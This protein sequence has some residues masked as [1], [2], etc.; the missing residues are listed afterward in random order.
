MHQQVRIAPDRRGEMHIR[1]EGEAEVADVLRRVNRALQ[2][3]QQDGLQQVEV[4]TG[5]DLLQDLGVVLGSR[6]RA[7]GELQP[8]LGE[9]V[10]QR[11]DPVLGGHLVH[12]VQHRLA[13]LGDEIAGADV[14]R[15]HALLDQAVRVVTLLGDDF[16]DLAARVE[17]HAR[18]DRFEVDRAALLA[19]AVQRLEDFVERRQ[20]RRR[21]AR[22]EL[23]PHLGV[24]Q[25]RLGAEH[26]RIELVVAHFALR[27]DR[28][29]AHHRQ[30]IDVGI[31]RAQAVG[32]LLR[33]HRDHAAREVHRGTALARR[34]VERIAV[35][36]VVADIGDRHPQAPVAAL[37]AGVDRVVE[38]LRRLAVDG[39]EVELAQVAPPLGVLRLHRARQGLR[40]RERFLRKLVRQ[41]EL[42]QRDLDLHPGVG[43]VA[44]HLGDAA[45][46]LRVLGRRLDQL[47]GH[48]L[49]GLHLAR[50]GQDD[51]VRDAPVL[52]H[53]VGDAVLEMH[54]TDDAALR[55]LEDLD[56]RAHRPPAVVAARDAHRSAVAVHQAAHLGGGKEHRRAAVVGHEE[57]VTVGVALDAPGHRGDA[58]RDEQRAGAV[59]HHLARALERGERNVELAALVPRNTQAL[60]E[61]VG[62]H[63][64]AG[65]LENA[66]G[67]RKILLL[68]RTR[69]SPQRASTWSSFSHCSFRLESRLLCRGG[70][71]G[72]RTR[73]RS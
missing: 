50:V 29:L 20:V 11:R 71:I 62:V 6:Y 63:R 54:A 61:L 41:I 18:L 67:F 5:A 1:V 59:A 8:Q 66:Q 10:A 42:A 3:A 39:D 19:L 52:R 68:F 17:H 23:G 72:R 45:D 14:R 35:P 31:E 48:D 28:H 55:A 7:A 57:A 26:R 60:R 21:P 64:R 40:L 27:A 49:A 37:A 13:T 9:E 24:G 44:E 12:A 73:F 22:G 58:P 47:D 33:Q 25:A 16:L 51:V 15:Q 70:G 46:G 53:E 38:V 69:A 56:H 43:V 65:A 36:D 32:D 4:G 30:A 2:R 34:E